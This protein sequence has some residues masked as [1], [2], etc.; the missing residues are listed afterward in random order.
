MKTMTVKEFKDHAIQAVAT[1]SH[2]GEP[3]VLTENGQPVV[4]VLPYIK[5]G[6]E[7]IP[8]KLAHLFISEDD[9]VSP[10]GADIWDVAR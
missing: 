5:P 6:I 4:Q 8:G 3:I 7:S 9:I 10:L 1:V 2:S